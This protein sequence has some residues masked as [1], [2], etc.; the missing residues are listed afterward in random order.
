MKKIIIQ[1]GEKQKTV[2]LPD[3][4]EVKIICHDGK[5]KTI[6]TTVKEKM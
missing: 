4:G 5:I 6:E 1:D 3:Y 2:N